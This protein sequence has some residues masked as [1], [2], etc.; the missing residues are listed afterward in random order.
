MFECDAALM[1]RSRSQCENLERLPDRRRS[2]GKSRDLH[3]H[4]E[5]PEERRPGT[6]KL[7][8]RRDHRPQRR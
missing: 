5:K 6:E 8:Y 2:G 3:R 4:P 7:R 1:F